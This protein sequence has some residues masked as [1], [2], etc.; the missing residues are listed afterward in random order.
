M[1]IDYIY[2]LVN[3]DFH[4]T[5]KKLLLLKSMYPMVKFNKYITN[6]HISIILTNL[7]DLKNCSALVNLVN[8]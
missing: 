8:Q 3:A 4:F 1:L 6:F 2:Q 7:L 5:E